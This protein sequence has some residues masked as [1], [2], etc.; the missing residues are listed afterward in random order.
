[1]LCTDSVSNMPCFI[2]SCMFGSRTEGWRIKERGTNYLDC[3]HSTFSYAEHVLLLYPQI[4]FQYLE[5]LWKNWNFSLHLQISFQLGNPSAFHCVGTHMA[6]KHCA[7]NLATRKRA[8]RQFM[9]PFQAHMIFLTVTWL[10]ASCIC[11]SFQRR[12]LYCIFT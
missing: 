7:E 5:G 10:T 4:F 12:T 8:R 6:V 2:F 9:T 1:M 3:C 11:G